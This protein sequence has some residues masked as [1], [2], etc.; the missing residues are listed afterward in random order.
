MRK[1]P[2]VAMFLIHHKPG[3]TGYLSY[4]GVF[5]LLGSIAILFALTLHISNLMNR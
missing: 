4:S 5:F 2:S 3:S 1:I